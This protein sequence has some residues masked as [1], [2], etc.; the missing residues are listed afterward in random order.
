MKMRILMCLSVL[1]V[2]FVGWHLGIQIVAKITL[3]I[4]FG[5]IDALAGGEDLPEVEIVCGETE[6]PCWAFDYFTNLGGIRCR[7]TDDPNNEC[8]F[9]Y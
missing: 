1:I 4:S 8:Y 6:G 3:D 7:R 9:V 2:A 5:N